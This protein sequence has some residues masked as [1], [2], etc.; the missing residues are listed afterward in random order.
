[1]NRTHRP[2]EQTEKIVG[3]VSCYSCSL[4]NDDRRHNIAIRILHRQI[5]QQTMWKLD[6]FST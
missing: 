3:E 1:V 2:T 6:S 4:D 5:W